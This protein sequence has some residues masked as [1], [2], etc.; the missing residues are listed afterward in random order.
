MGA[1]SICIKDMAGLLSPYGAEHLIKALKKEIAVPLE[2]HNHCTTGLGHM[3]ALKAAEAGV[4]IL[5]TALARSREP[6]ASPV[7]KPW[8]PRWRKAPGIPG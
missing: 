1:D 6:Q 2:L 7:P 8:W 4:D 3:T 5:D